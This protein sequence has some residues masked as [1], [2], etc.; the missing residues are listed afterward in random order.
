MKEKFLSLV[1]FS[2]QRDNFRTEII[3][4]ITTFFTM[5]YILALLPAMFCLHR[6]E[7]RDSLLNRC[8]LLLRCQQ[9]LVH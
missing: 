2:L 4:G 5:V 7:K 3:S 8:L 6:L 9:L 1:G